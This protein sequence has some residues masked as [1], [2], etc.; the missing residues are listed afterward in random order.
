MML[1]ATGSWLIWFF[2]AV[3][4]CATRHEALACAC[5]T[6]VGERFD[7][8]TKLE[9]YHLEE[10]QKLHF[11]RIANLFLGEADPDSVRGI[12]KAAA[13]YELQAVWQT[14]RLLFSFRDETGQSG[15]LS[16]AMPK[17]I[18]IFSVDPRS[19][20]EGRLG[21]SLYKEWRL[22]A[23]AAGGGVFAAGLSVEQKLT[24]VFQGRG[25]NCTSA[26]DFT[27]WMLV[28][29]GPKAKYHFFGNVTATR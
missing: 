8:V 28:M 18:A 26:S 21:P 17:T 19:E 20:P 1:R 22:T 13:K 11:D 7:L 29:D 25:N 3:L 2:V 4:L 16:F 6:S 23:K 24:L 10:L 27:H 9:K 5:C 15:D 14:N 12:T